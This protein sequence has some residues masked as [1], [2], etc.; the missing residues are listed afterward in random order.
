MIFGVLIRLKLVGALKWS[1]VFLSLLLVSCGGGSNS[2]GASVQGDGLPSG[3]LPPD[4]SGTSPTVP[5]D[6]NEI[7][8]H[9]EVLQKVCIACHTETGAARSAALR[10]SGV[11]SASAQAENL[12]VLDDYVFSR[13]GRWLLDKAR[14]LHNHGGGQQVVPGSASYDILVDYLEWLTGEHYRSSIYDRMDYA[15]ESPATT[16]RRASLILTGVIP[17]TKKMAAMAGINDSEL[18]VEILE[19]MSGEGFR[20][21]I[22]RGAND[23]LLVRSLHRSSSLTNSFY[24]YYPVFRE[25]YDELGDGGVGYARAVARELAE[26]PLELIAYVVE[27]DR[28][29]TEILTADYTMVSRETAQIFR[30]NTKPDQGHFVP[31]VNRGQHVSGTAWRLASNDWALSTPITIPHA[32]I[33]TDPAFLRQYPTTATNRNRA[34]SRWTFMHFLGFDIESSAENMVLTSAL[35]D[36]HN[37]TLNN[38]NCTV[39]HAVL[40]PVAGA[41]QNFGREGIY[42]QGGWGWDS[43]AYSYKRT[44]L[45]SPGDTWYADM[46]PPGFQ[47]QPINDSDASLRELGRRIA[48]DPRFAQGAVKFWWPAVFG[49]PLLGDNLSRLQADAKL[50][51][52]ADLA[53]R[54]VDSNFNLKMLLADMLMSDWFR[55]THLYDTRPKDEV[56]IYTG[57]RRLLTPEELFNKTVSLTGIQDLELINQLNLM[58]GGIDSLNYDQ[59][60]R[61]VNTMM[62]RVAERHALRNACAIVA[63]E[64]N[65]EPEARRL[66]TLVAREDVP[67]HGYRYNRVLP[68]AAV[69]VITDSIMVTDAPGQTIKYSVGQLVYA[70]EGYTTNN[71]YLDYLEIYQP[72]GSLLVSGEVGELYD[73]YPWITGNAVDGIIQPYRIRRGRSLDLAIPVEMSG[74]YRIEL[75]VRAR[76]AGNHLDVSVSPTVDFANAV[77]PATVK[78]RQQIAKLVERMH[79]ETLL[80]DSPKIVA[81]TNLFIDLRANAMRR[82]AGGNLVES[83]LRCEYS[84]PDLSRAQW[85]ADPLHTLRAWRGVVTALMTD[86]SYFFE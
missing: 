22:R 34:R 28:P 37:P 55:V 4:S 70:Q 57:G 39:C 51:T 72:D 86:F 84:H 48:Q 38:S 67:G 1:V 63:S 10:F 11:K 80:H 76:T 30:A 47:G 25:R 43:L 42:R 53:E 73:R 64:F 12:A 77:D 68:T 3:S 81:Y 71:V 7:P 31:A 85:G 6:W 49:E 45:Y 23:Q 69:E 18:R 21:F 61:E 24:H 40:D 8:V 74:E 82:S 9:A 19:L 5:V 54:F 58:H 17:S 2:G 29:Y 59:R 50:A 35:K 15:I 66:F 36:E 62:S 56:A 83:G 16:Y 32:G 52:L 41:F 75:S 78:I 79:G 14:G 20:E 65:V 44:E 33:L 27:S 13:G 46:L 60:L 26:A